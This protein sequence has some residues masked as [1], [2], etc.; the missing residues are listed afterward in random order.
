LIDFPFLS[1]R[2]QQGL[3]AALDVLTSMFKTSA[4]LRLENL[5][6]YGNN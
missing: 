4:Q 2:A 5:A 3:M 1:W 6:L